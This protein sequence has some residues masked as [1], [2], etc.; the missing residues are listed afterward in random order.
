MFPPC[1]LRAPA[2]PSDSWTVCPLSYNLSFAHPAPVTMAS[3]LC[4]F[5]HMVQ[6]T[7]LCTGC[8][9]ECSSPTAL[10]WPLTSTTS[11][12][13]IRLPSLN[14]RLTP[15]HTPADP[16]PLICL[17]FP[18]QKVCQPLALC[19]TYCLLCFLFVYSL[20]P[21]PQPIIKNRTF[22][23]EILI[24]FVYQWIPKVYSRFKYIFVTLFGIDRQSF[25]KK[26]LGGIS[27][28]WQN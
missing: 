19:A 20:I 1:I 18:P 10:C 16:M 8:S 23:A 13:S 6:P 26:S 25:E 15:T 5:E 7:G 14:S 3:C 17:F 22:G 2:S 21:I 27:H 9:L 24:Y 4:V 11:H 28:F 12:F